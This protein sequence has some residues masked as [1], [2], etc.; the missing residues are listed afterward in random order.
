[1][2]DGGIGE[3]AADEALGVKHGVVGVHGHLILGGVPHQALRVGEGHIA[4]GDPVT[5][6]VGNDLHPTVLEHANTENKIT[7]N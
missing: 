1:M 4:G 5:L 6:V 7:V 3:L 2:L